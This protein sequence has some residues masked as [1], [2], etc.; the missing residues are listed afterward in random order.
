[1]MTSAGAEQSMSATS[2][3]DVANHKHKDSSSSWMQKPKNLFKTFSKQKNGSK[4]ISYM[5]SENKF[6]K[7]VEKQSIFYKI[8]I[9]YFFVIQLNVALPW[10]H[11]YLQLCITITE[12]KR[13][14]DFTFS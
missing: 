12:R 8:C 7:A 2:N 13:D 3:T 14:L 11:S 9:A 5:I 4:V 10:I 6:W 1:M